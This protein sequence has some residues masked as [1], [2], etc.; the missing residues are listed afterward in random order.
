MSEPE[1]A[2][3]APEGEA[4]PAEEGQK[5]APTKKRRHRRK[6][7]KRHVDNRKRVDPDKTYP[8]ADAVALLKQTTNAKFDETVEVAVKLGIDAKQSEQQIRGTVILPKGTGKSVRVLVFAEG[9]KATEA[10][11]AG[12]DYVGSK[13]LADKI[14][15]EGWHDFEIALATPD[16]MK[17]VGRLGKVLGP[18]GKMPSPKAGTLTNDIAQAVMEFKGGK[19]EYRNDKQGNL[20]CPVGKKS[21]K[22]EDLVANL[23]AVLDHIESSKPSS[24]KGNFLRRVTISSTMGPGIRLAL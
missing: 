3:A 1:L 8:L 5:D 24:S 23:R 19:I 4:K 7:S 6:P 22:A 14:A 20:C 2:A 21:F 16:M 15:N 10:Q 9:E 12:A 11:Q 18:H 17:Y 13:D